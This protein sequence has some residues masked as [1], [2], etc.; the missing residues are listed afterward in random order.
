M[1]LHSEIFY[2]LIF[3][4]KSENFTKAKQDIWNPCFTPQGMQYKAVF[5]HTSKIMLVT[6]IT[7]P[8][9]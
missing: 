1:L 4:I 6:C 2:I 5:I 7:L 3:R 8:S 9:G